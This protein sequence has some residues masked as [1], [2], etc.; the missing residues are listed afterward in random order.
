[1][2][3]KWKNSS[4]RNT[5]I[6]ECNVQNGHNN[7]QPK[8]TGK[9]MSKMYVTVNFMFIEQLYKSNIKYCYK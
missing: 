1:M 6:V 8:V 4:G 9:M 3:Y 7:K 5:D 2:H